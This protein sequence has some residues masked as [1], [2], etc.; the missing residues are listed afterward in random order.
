[1]KLLIPTLLSICLSCFSESFQDANFVFDVQEEERLLHV[2][3][4]IK[5]NCY[6]ITVIEGKDQWFQEV[7]YGLTPVISSKEF[8]LHDKYMVHYY[9]SFAVYST[10][11][12]QRIVFTKDRKCSE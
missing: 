11:E 6:I 9:P 7:C 4:Y 12:T 2:G 3:W 8:V 5:E 10:E 1:M